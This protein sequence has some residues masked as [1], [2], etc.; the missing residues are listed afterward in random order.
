MLYTFLLSVYGPLVSLYDHNNEH[1]QHTDSGFPALCRSTR[2]H[3][4]PNVS[5]NN[6]IWYILCNIPTSIDRQQPQIVTG[7]QVHR[8][9]VRIYISL[10]STKA[11]HSLN[12][13]WLFIII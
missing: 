3:S 7:C 10:L 1:T 6:V 2:L 12:W 4:P 8:S 9:H 11:R 5:S 13:R